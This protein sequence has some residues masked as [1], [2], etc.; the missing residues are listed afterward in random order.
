M[1]EPDLLPLF[2]P[3]SVAVIGAS[4]REDAIGHLVVKNLVE[5]GFTGPVFPINPQARSVRGIRAYPDLDA[6]PDE[7]DLVVLV[8]PAP[9]VLDALEACG[10]KGVR[11]C[12]VITAGFKESGG[13]GRTREQD[14]QAAAA[15]HGIR[16]V[17]PN[18]MGVIASDP[19]VRLNASFAAVLPRAG[20]VAFASQSGA[21]GE[22]FLA[23]AQE[24]GL[25]LS[26]FVSLGNKADVDGADLLAWW[27]DD[28]RTKVILLYLES[29]ADPAAFAA[30]AR[31][32]TRAGKPVLLVK[33]GRSAAGARA[34][35]SHTG[36]LAGVDEAMSAFL[37][38]CGVLRVTRVEGLFD[39]ARAFSSQPVPRG[40]RVAILTNAGGPGIMAADAATAYGLSMAVLSEQTTAAMRAVLPA[41]ASVANPVDAIA[42]AGAAAYGACVAALLADPGVD[43]LLPIYVGPGT[44]DVAAV[45]HEVVKS[46]ELARR[47]G[48]Q[49]KPVLACFMGGRVPE[50]REVLATAGIPLYD[51][52]EGAAQA[53][54]TMTRFRRWL[55]QPQ[56]SPW[57]GQLDEAAVARALEGSEAGWLPAARALSLIEAA[58]IPVP[59]WAEA[60]TSTEAATRAPEFGWPVVLKLDHPGALHKS[61]L[62]GVRL[63]LNT[64]AE[65]QD[66]AD[67]MLERVR[68]A[69][70]D[71]AAARFLLQAQRRGGR[72]L[73]VGG[74]HDAAVGPLVLCGLGGVH[75]EALRD[76][77]LRVL[78][79]SDHDAHTMPRELRGHALLTGHRGE[80]PADLDAVED[81]LQRLAALLERCPRVEELEVNPLAVFDQGHGVLALDARVRLGE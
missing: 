6:V 55:E 13:A 45:A 73:I 56:G 18:C 51:F 71:P 1:P 52:P 64:A 4:R 70:L 63:N 53:L 2:R 5:F 42:T 32:I 69:R 33:S 7:V 10:R 8:V 61:E 65:V 78:P 39:A 23:R 40:R 68:G 75:T 22:V 57:T 26:A 38:Q 35:A 20:N 41:E 48:A 25:G 49:G 47:V 11:A 66:A 46:V 3:R 50:A 27:G 14:L 77:S 36:A 76:V 30:H 21:L 15:R 28:P 43:A 9:L 81:V 59:P 74:R 34:S 29:L 80:P 54:G 24:Q 79:L 62:G 60:A 67:Q 19:E 72:E 16:V 31:R 12:V 58:G 37:A 17:G 44:H